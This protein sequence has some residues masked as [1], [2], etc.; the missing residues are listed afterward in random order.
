MDREHVHFMCIDVAHAENVSKT[1]AE[2]V[3]SPLF[4]SQLIYSTIRIA[5]WNRKKL[6]IAVLGVLCL[7]HWG[8]L[9][10][11]MFIV[12]AEWD[13]KARVCAVTQTNPSLL[14]VTFFFSESA[15]S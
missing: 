5:L 4:A 10:R 9:Y 12:V 6:V 3:S 8:L 2:G 13:P 14:N 15:A 11:T 7:A 1:L